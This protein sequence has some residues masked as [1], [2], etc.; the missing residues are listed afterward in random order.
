[1]VD[2]N[3]R[4]VCRGTRK[5]T[6]KLGLWRQI[7]HI[8][9][10]NKK[11][12]LLLCKRPS[13][14]KSYPSLITSSAG[15]K[16]EIGEGYR[17]AAKRELKEELGISASLHEIGLYRIKSKIH[18]NMLHKLFVANTD[19]VYPNKNEIS[20]ARFFTM[21]AVLRETKKHPKRFVLPFLGALSLYTKKKKKESFNG[22]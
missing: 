13:W 22:N 19:V 21:A 17:E 4:F 18:G 11:N 16:V 14:A 15:G 2:H 10:F 1:M 9:V 3:G 6:R 5:E 12:E 7:V 20:E 8:F